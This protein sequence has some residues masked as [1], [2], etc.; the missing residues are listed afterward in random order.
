MASYGLWRMGDIL[1]TYKEE[2]SKAMNMLAENKKT[3]F[4]GQGVNY[5][6]CIYGTLNGVPHEKKIELPVIEDTQM[7]MSIGLALDGMIPITIYPRMD[8]LIL[9]LNQL[10]NHLDK[11]EE[12]SRKEL[13][14]KVIIR[15]IVG[16]TTPL[17][18]GPQHCQDH[19]HL[20]RCALTNVNVIK[21]NNKEDIVPEYT[22]AL[23]SD[24]STILVEVKNLYES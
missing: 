10:I 6:G 3:I 21:L 4:L 20:L 12:M 8:F 17:Y 13:K 22:K 16:G 5:G 9:A 23:N 14:P 11:I 2:I 7:G 24:K 19:T 1:M 15:C 18:P